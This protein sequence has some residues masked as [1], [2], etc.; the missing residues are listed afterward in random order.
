VVCYNLKAVT[1]KTNVNL[2]NFGAAL[3]MSA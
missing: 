3:P 1:N 2:L